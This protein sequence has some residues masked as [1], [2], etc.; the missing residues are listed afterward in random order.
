[1]VA[2]AIV[3]LPAISHG[4]RRPN[5]PRGHQWPASKEMKKVGK[6]CKERLRVA[7]LTFRSA[8]ARKQIVTPILV[9]EMEFAGLK[10]KPK[11]KRGPFVMDCHLAE[12]LLLV[13]PTWLELGVREIRFSS[14]H[15]YRNVRVSGKELPRLSRHALG[16]AIDVY[17]VVDVDG[18]VHSVAE[19]YYSLDL[20][21]P[22]VESQA[23][24]S[25]EFRRVISPI[26]DPK[27]HHD[28]LHIEARVE[29]PLTRVAKRRAKRRSRRA[30]ARRE[31]RRK[32]RSA[33]RRR[34]RAR[35]RARRA[36]RR[37]A[38]SSRRRERAAKRP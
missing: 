35:A 3:S 2:A 23:N 32:A 20:F 25:G 14:I 26:R 29:Y 38:S 9:P 27:S 16:L 8:R 15:V 18:R 36:K 30:R 5:M 31:A 12:A 37:A 24:A 21:L 33:K 7:G 17:D 11:W 28:H 13:A 1:M 19:H 34:S 22:A 4:K 6:A 10:V